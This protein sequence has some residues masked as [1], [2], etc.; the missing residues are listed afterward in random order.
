LKQ[1]QTTKQTQNTAQLNQQA[2]AQN[3]MMMPMN[4]NPMAQVPAASDKQGDQGTGQQMYMDQ[5]QYIYSQMALHQHMFQ[6]YQSMLAQQM[7]MN[8]QTQN[9]VKNGATN[10]AAASIPNFGAPGM[11]GQM[12]GVPMV[13]PMGVPYMVP[14]TGMDQSQQ[15]FMPM[16]PMPMM[17]PPAQGVA[18]QQ[19][20]NKN[21]E[22]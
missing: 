3:P 8:Q 10:P 21:E 7:A 16:V 14:P 18:P 19:F 2:F 13:P 22:K 9:G 4:F 5:N 11:N 15:Q 6:Q 17:Y 1:A 12:G 20:Y